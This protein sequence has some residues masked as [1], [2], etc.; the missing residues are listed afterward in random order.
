MPMMK[1]GPGDAG[2]AVVLSIGNANTYAGFAGENAVPE[3][4]LL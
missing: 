4:K 2:P 3:G 1:K